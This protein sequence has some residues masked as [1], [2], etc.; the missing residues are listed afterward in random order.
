M[1][2]FLGLLVLSLK[3]VFE[4]LLHPLMELLLLGESLIDA[5]EDILRLLIFSLQS[6][7]VILKFTEVL[8]L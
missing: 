8:P 7:E 1:T 4:L 3:S 2:S 6:I 5:A